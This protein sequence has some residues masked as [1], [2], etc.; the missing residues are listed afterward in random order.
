MFSISVLV[1]FIIGTTLIFLR[2][3]KIKVTFIKNYSI[4]EWENLIDEA[5]PKDDEKIIRFEI[6]RD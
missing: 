2:M 4:I 3:K 5:W 1:G 6:E